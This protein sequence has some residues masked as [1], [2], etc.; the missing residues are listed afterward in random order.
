MTQGSARTDLR[1]GQL[2]VAEG[3]AFEEFYEIFCEALPASERKPRELIVALATRSDYYLLIGEIG[4]RVMSFA[5]L[6]LSDRYPIALLEYLG[7]S[8]AARGKGLG[9]EMF[10]AAIDR[11]GSDSLVIEVDSDRQDSGD[12]EMRRR[13]KQFYARLGAR[14]IPGVEYRMPKIGADSPPELDLMVRPG[15]GR[16]HV[17]KDEMAAWIEDIFRG[18]YHRAVPREELARMIQAMPSHVDLIP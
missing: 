2:N 6:Y 13:R 10:R 4:G 12:L 17:T 15:G 9:A 1:I 3:P 8:A 11:I 5:I 18:A 7:T 16:T 14:Q